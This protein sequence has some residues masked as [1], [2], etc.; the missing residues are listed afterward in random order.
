MNSI[1]KFIAKMMFINKRNKRIEDTMSLSQ[2]KL[3]SKSENK[4]IKSLRNIEEEESLK[5]RI[6]I[7]SSIT[8]REAP[9]QI[10]VEETILKSVTNHNVTEN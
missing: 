4:I 10:W 1:I 6:S 5:K 3:N 7:Y 9:V 8:I 2:E